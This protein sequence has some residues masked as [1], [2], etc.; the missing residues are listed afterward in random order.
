[1]ILEG[2]IQSTGMMED[3]GKG[4]RTEDINVLR[5]VRL[6]SP[7]A[8]TVYT[9]NRTCA[10]QCSSERRAVR[11][12]LHAYGTMQVRGS[13]QDAT[14][15]ICYNTEHVRLTKVSPPRSLLVTFAGDHWERRFEL[16]RSAKTWL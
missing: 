15:P 10:L 16:E 5:E 12:A 14:R 8:Q 11:I 13:S 4:N 3:D 6:S 7:E 9:G 1:M 2:V